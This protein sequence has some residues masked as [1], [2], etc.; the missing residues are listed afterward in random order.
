MLHPSPLS[1]R[2]RCRIWSGKGQ[3][4]TAADLEALSAAYAAR[5]AEISDKTAITRSEVVRA[6]KLGSKLHLA[7]GARLQQNGELVASSAAADRRSR[8]FTKLV[9][10]Y[11][12]C[13]SA[14]AFI[15]R[16][17]GDAD[18]IAPSL[19]TTARAGAVRSRRPTHRQRRP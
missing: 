6:A 5:G 8:A 11:E 7:L 3:F 10:A 9:K 18:D 17:E 12:E 15:R 19:S 4:D 1:S 14:I 13:R 2:A 16:R